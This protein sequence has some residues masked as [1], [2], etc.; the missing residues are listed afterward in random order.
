[1]GLCKVSLYLGLSRRA[2]FPF[3]HAI[4]PRGD[5][6][7][8][9][10]IR[11]SPLC[12]AK[13]WAFNKFWEKSGAIADGKGWRRGMGLFLGKKK[14]KTQGQNYCLR[15]RETSKG[16]RATE[17]ASQTCRSLHPLGRSVLASCS[18]SVLLFPHIQGKAHTW[19]RTNM[20]HHF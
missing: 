6:L 13:V 19:G 7:G 8:L 3:L 15:K 10:S 2:S 18:F 4:T 16:S 9:H 17:G 20:V 12:R 11:T 5:I 14:K 1:M